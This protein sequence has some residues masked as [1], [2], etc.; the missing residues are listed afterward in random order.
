MWFSSNN[1]RDNNAENCRVLCATQQNAR[2][3]CD[4][5]I[6]RRKRRNKKKKR[7]IQIH[8]SNDET[9]PRAPW[10]RRW[11][12]DRDSVR[13]IPFAFGVKCSR[14]IRK[15]RYF[16]F[17][18][19][20]YLNL[21]FVIILSFRILAMAQCC[22]LVSWQ[23]FLLFFLD[24]I[25]LLL[26]VMITLKTRTKCHDWIDSNDKKEETKACAFEPFD[27]ELFVVGDM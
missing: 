5:V 3:K 24:A 27:V 9:W 6:G 22:L 16:S 18:I 1:W 4:A 7:E 11:T 10:V 19:V 8:K 26:L 23:L 2:G 12:R 17:D 20:I 15:L 14:F 25:M 21:Y 13:I